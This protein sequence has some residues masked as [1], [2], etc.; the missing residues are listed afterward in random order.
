LKRLLIVLCLLF[1]VSCSRSYRLTF[2]YYV[3]NGQEVITE[4]YKIEKS[5]ISEG[6]H[7]I[8]IPQGSGNLT[9]YIQAEVPKTV[10]VAT[11][12]SPNLPLLRR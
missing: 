4:K 9:V 6:E 2:N 10:D 3:G 1:L 11:D 7:I 8:N 5:E 12:I